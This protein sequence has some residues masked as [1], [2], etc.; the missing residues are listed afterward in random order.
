MSEREPPHEPESGSPPAARSTSGPTAGSSTSSARSRLV[1]R[2]LFRVSRG[3]LVVAVLLCVLGVG[4][5]AQVRNTQE[6]G[7]AG[8]RQADLIHL[9][10][11][12]TTRADNLENEIAELEAA[13]AQLLADDDEAAEAAAA[14]RLEAYQILAGTVGASGPGIVLRVQ[15]PDA[16]MTPE[17]LM[18]LVQ[19]LRDAGA[20]A[21][22]IDDVRVVA[23]TWFAASPVGGLT[24]SGVP[25]EAP[26]EIRAI[27]DGHTLSGALAIPGGFND[28]VRRSGGIVDID[29]V[30]LV[31]VDALHEPAEPRY[32]H[33]VP[34]EGE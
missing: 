23:T 24:V 29:T 12:V 22:Q 28:V 30:E 26:Y 17:D 32:A 13:R 5:V 16:A 10:D 15:D 2:G 34:A 4:V 11:D 20:E 18:A 27:G 6:E 33:P 8:L 25:V 19:E 3:S 7:L 21:I 1:G 14:Q 31:E 9:L